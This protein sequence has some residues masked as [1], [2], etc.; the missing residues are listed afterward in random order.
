MNYN[1]FFPI[2]EYYSKVV[3]PINP[4]RYKIKSEKAFVCPV[5][6][7]HDP[8]LGLIHSK[9]GDICHCFGCNFW[10]DVVQLHQRVCKRHFKK[11]LSEEEAVQDL[12]RLFSVNYDDI[13]KEGLENIKDKGAR[14]EVALNEAIENFDIGDF[15]RL[16]YEGKVQK[17]PIGYFNAVVMTMVDS[18]KEKEN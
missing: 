8:S 13:P 14:Q 15:Q 16:I 4:Q 6:N 7:D 11:Y 9:N 10:G 2:E 3:I 12:C 1:K 18:C 17:R 5:H